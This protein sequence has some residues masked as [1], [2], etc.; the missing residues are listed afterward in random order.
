MRI[1]FIAEKKHKS[2][3]RDNCSERKEVFVSG[4]SGEVEGVR[5]REG[6]G[7]GEGTVAVR[8]Q[9]RKRMYRSDICNEEVSGGVLGKR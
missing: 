5:G 6:G 4:E 7:G 9:E 3:E 8:F 2:K 1:Y